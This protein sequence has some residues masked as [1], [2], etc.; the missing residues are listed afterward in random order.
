MSTVVIPP[1]DVVV[2]AS[3]PCAGKGLG[4]RNHF[5]DYRPF[6]GIGKNI[7]A[8]HIEEGAMPP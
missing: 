5:A 6:V 1:P 2:F 8:P 3:L 7:R 4:Q